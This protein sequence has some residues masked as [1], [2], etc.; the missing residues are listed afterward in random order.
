MPADRVQNSFAMWSAASNKLLTPEGSILLVLGPYNSERIFSE[1]WSKDDVKMFMYEHVRRRAG[2]LRQST[3]G[4][5]F[6]E[7]AAEVIPWARTGPDDAMVPLVERPDRFVV[8]ATPGENSVSSVVPNW[9]LSSV[10]IV[11]AIGT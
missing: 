5:R 9:S 7:R 11:K 4:Q 6:L 2:E 10:P 3:M 1:G 8:M